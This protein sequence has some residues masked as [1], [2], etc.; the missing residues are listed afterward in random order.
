ML[1]GPV[2]LLLAMRRRRSAV[3]AIELRPS[4]EG[5]GRGARAVSVRT[6]DMI[7]RSSDGERMSG[8]TRPPSG[9]EP[10]G[11]RGHGG[12]D[13]LTK[14]LA[15]IRKPITQTKPIGWWRSGIGDAKATAFTVN[16][17][18]ERSG[19]ISGASSSST[20]RYE[21]H[22]VVSGTRSC[23]SH[24]LF[25]DNPDAGPKHVC[26]P[27]SVTCL[28]SYQHSLPTS[29]QHSAEIYVAPIGTQ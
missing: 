13:M 29:Y 16:P 7:E 4:S 9:T 2:L 27:L 15:V 23:T 24:L 20:R 26:K 18:W 8:D 12:L 11:V 6:F 21:R 14:I 22:E 5:S 3:L 25:S 1:M 19:R 17:Q 28:A 10:R